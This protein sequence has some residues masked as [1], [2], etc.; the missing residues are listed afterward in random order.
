MKHNRLV[1]IGGVK[2]AGLDRVS[3]QS[4][5]QPSRRLTIRIANSLAAARANPPTGLSVCLT[6]TLMPNISK[7]NQFSKAF[8]TFRHFT[9]L[10]KLASLDI[11]DWVYNWLVDYFS[12]HSHCTAFHG[13]I[14]PLLNIPSSIIQGSAVGPVSYV[15]NAV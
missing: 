5:L 12:G 4:Y 8:D 3:T 13:Q 1:C 10:Q 15:V 7:T 2:L 11:P 14:S 6:A 9:L